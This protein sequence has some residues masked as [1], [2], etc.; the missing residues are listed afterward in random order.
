MNYI[1]W[2]VSHHLRLP[3]QLIFECHLL[4][5]HLS[6]KQF[7]VQF[8]STLC[9]LSKSLYPVSYCTFPEPR[10]LNL[11]PFVSCCASQWLH[12]LYY[13]RQWVHWGCVHPCFKWRSLFYFPTPDLWRT[14]TAHSW[15]K[16]TP[17]Y[18]FCYHWLRPPQ[19]TNQDLIHKMKFKKMLYIHSTN[20]NIG[21]FLESINL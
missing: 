15:I 21:L 13:E 7:S 8:H 5:N 2:F 1:F 11:Y 16:P 14:A 4:H 10:L 12:T 17:Q 6:S 9:T 19:E 20:N 18:C 3:G